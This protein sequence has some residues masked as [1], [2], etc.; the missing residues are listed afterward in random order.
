MVGNEQVRR[1]VLVV[2]GAG[3]SQGIASREGALPLMRAWATGLREALDE[4]DRG[5]ADVIGLKVDLDGDLFEERLGDFLAFQANLGLVHGL[6]RLGLQPVGSGTTQI[7]QWLT[8]ATDRCDRLVHAIWTNL[9]ENFGFR[10]FNGQLAAQAYD[11]LRGWFSQQPTHLSI[12]TTNYDL[13]AEEAFRLLG[14]TVLDG[15]SGSA[16]TAQTLDLD[17]LMNRRLES[18]E[19]VPVLHLHGAVGWYRSSD[20]SGSITRHPA[21]Q[22]YYPHLG[23]PALLLPDGRKTISSLVGAERV[24][25]AFQV[26]LDEASHVLVLGHSLH[27]KH[28][29]ELIKGGPRVAVAWHLDELT[30]DDAQRS[31]RDYVNRKLPGA[32]FIP[33]S[34]GPQTMADRGVINDWLTGAN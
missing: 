26:L 21:D 16:Y 2:T 7:D 25:D 10:S 18:V 9:Y 24:W 22:P 3:A 19:Y 13:S 11:H 31:A 5:V 14:S 34:F 32:A 27:D 20:G 8:V 29:V 6:R 4:G 17:D 23:P 30:T 28:L 12:A 15:F 1:R 33:C